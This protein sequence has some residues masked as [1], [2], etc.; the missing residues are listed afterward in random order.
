MPAWSIARYLTPAQCAAVCA[1]AAEGARCPLS[2]ALGLAGLASNGQVAAALEVD[3]PLGPLEQEQRLAAIAE[4]LAAYDAQQL[5]ADQVP[6]V[7]G[8]DA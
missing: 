7:L 6:A 1:A 8:V 5:T 2:R 3:A 4:F